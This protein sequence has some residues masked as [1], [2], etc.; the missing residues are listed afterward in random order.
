MEVAIIHVDGMLLSELVDGPGVFSA[1]AVLG[2]V[3]VVAV[4]VAHVWGC[5]LVGVG[6]VTIVLMD[7]EVAVI[8][9]GV[10]GTSTTTGGGT[11]AAMGLGMMTAICVVV[12]N[13]GVGSGVSSMG[14]WLL[15]PGGGEGTP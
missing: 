1:V 8:V 5:A 4:D 3:K 7:A 12:D 9:V 13:K 15:G 2:V 10:A 6:T 11:G 14:T